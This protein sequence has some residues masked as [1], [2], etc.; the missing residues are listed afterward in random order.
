MDTTK[1]QVAK[2]A[3]KKAKSAK[4]IADIYRA[5]FSAL[6]DEQ[7][8]TFTLSIMGDKFTTLT[9]HVISENEISAVSMPF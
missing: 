6:T 4:E 1:K 2:L 8:N 3:I 5:E 7:I 9:E